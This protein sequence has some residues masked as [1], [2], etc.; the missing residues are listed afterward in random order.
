[1]DV[2]AK[3]YVKYKPLKNNDTDYEIQEN[4]IVYKGTEYPVE[5][6]VHPGE[7]AFE[8]MDIL[9][10]HVMRFHEGTNTS[11]FT[12]GYSNA[13]KSYTW[14]DSNNGII[15]PLIED[16]F[17]YKSNEF[18]IR[19]S[20]CELY[21]GRW[22]ELTTK[23]DDLKVIEKNSMI[24]FY[25]SLNMKNSLC[26][27]VHTIEEFKSKVVSAL[28][29]RKVASTQNNLTSSR[30]PLVFNIYLAEPQEKGIRYISR[31]GLLDLAGNERLGHF[32]GKKEQT[33]E[34]KY[35]NAD[36]YGL[37]QLIRQISKSQ[38]IYSH[39]YRTPLT[40]VFAQCKFLTVIGCVDFCSKDF[41]VSILQFLTEGTKIPN[42]CPDFQKRHDSGLALD[43]NVE[44]L[45]QT[46]EIGIDTQD[47]ID[48]SSLQ[49]M[50]HSSLSQFNLEISGKLEENLSLLLE[51]LNLLYNEK[52]QI[53]DHLKS[54]GWNDSIGILPW[55]TEKLR[56]RDILTVIGKEKVLEGKKLSQKKGIDYIPQ[57]FSVDDPENIPPPQ[58][59][60]RGKTDVQ[61]KLRRKHQ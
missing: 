31:L 28:K 57:F 6:I 5:K 12:Y 41:T 2:G 11:I 49:E 23:T 55:L 10:E 61:K 37:T 34:A 44:E 42:Y 16:L 48:F 25:S 20:I 22:K 26:S 33:T 32:T 46:D 21:N 52:S 13:G 27:T 47:L 14:F 45:P 30:S 9:L 38:K 29:I 40:R 35:I 7:N 53:F 60:K 19:L 17:K 18:E 39:N 36:I 1:M 54:F 50:I 4:A 58:G 24:H 3:F 15:W 43:N 8:K 51:K 56:K 59:K